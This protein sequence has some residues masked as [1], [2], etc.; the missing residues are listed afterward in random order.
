MNTSTMPVRIFVV[1]GVSGC[2]KSS[3]AEGLHERFG[4]PFQEGDALHPKANVAKMSAG[5]P[6]DDD[7]RRPWLATCA[8]WIKA[9]HEAGESAVLT[10]SAL[11]RSYRETLSQGMPDVWFI[12]LEVPVEVLRERLARRTHHYM[13]GS[14]LPTQLRTLEEPTADEQVIRVPT[15]E[16]VE[17]TIQATIDKLEVMPQLEATANLDAKPD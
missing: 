7:D 6:L 3:V 1:M 11:K 15:A 12:Y 5:I 2:G 17:G 13:P 14:L 9:R 16:T 8:A 10:C 4:W